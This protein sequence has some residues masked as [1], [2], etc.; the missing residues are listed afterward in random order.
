MRTLHIIVILSWLSSS[1]ALDVI[2]PGEP[3]AEPAAPE[4]FCVPLTACDCAD[5][6]DPCDSG[7][8]EPHSVGWHCCPAGR[9]G[10]L[11]CQPDTDG[12]PGC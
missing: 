2:E 8:L 4:P 1:C 9:G 6:W 10:S 7:G 12:V 5:E 11:S 3:G